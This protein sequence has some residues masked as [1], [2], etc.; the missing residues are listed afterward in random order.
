[1]PFPYLINHCEVDWL[2]GPFPSTFKNSKN[3]AFNTILRRTVK[4]TICPGSYSMICTEVMHIITRNT[5]THT[6]EYSFPKESTGNPLSPWYAIYFSGSW[7]SCPF[8]NKP[9][10][11][12]RIVH[13]HKQGEEKRG[14]EWEKYSIFGWEIYVCSMYVGGDKWM[15]MYDFWTVYWERERLTK[16]RAI[17]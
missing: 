2:H 10:S 15:Y 3:L 8:R 12:I 5:Q 6:P 11:S 17:L 1:M 16:C 4:Y 14:K 13:S 9:K 7:I